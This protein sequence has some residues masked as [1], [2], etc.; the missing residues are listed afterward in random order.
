MDPENGGKVE[1][2]PSIVAAVTRQYY[3]IHSKYGNSETYGKFGSL[4]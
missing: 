4:E 2:Y 1:K 3:K